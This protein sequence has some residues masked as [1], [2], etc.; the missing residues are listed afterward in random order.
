ML[1]N[2]VHI[3]KT[4]MIGFKTA[5]RKRDISTSAYVVNKLL[6]LQLLSKMDTLPM[7]Y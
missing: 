4:K 2:T 3:Y 7:I 5:K 1:Q 6:I